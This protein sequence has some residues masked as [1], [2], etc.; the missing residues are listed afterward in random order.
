MKAKKL[1]KISILFASLP[2]CVG[3]VIFLCW[4]IPRSFYAKDY[5]LLED[6]GIYCYFSFLAG[7]LIAVLL[8]L[9]WWIQSKMLFNLTGIIGFAIILLSYFLGQNLAKFGIE[10]QTK[11]FVRIDNCT[12]QDVV[13]RLHPYF[14]N[15]IKPLSTK[16][17]RHRMFIYQPEYDVVD[18]ER[19]LVLKTAT[20][21]IIK[22]GNNITLNLPTIGDGDCKQF[23]L[24]QN[25]ELKEDE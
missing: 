15:R 11:A 19:N 3:S 22:T 5:A 10:Q 24:D 25:F 1:Y 23:I 4:Y 14:S 17:N 20:L 9:I 21:E 7:L 13:L 12:R 18:N 6:I 16:S 8:L 2:L